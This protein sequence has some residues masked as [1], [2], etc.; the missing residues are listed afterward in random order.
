MF[1][2]HCN[3]DVVMMSNVLMNGTTHL[4]VLKIQLFIAGMV[5]EILLFVHHLMNCPNFVHKACA[6]VTCPIR[7]LSRIFMS[8]GGGGF[9]YVLLAGGS[10][11][12]IRTAFQYLTGSKLVA[13]HAEI[14]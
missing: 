7:F 4:K 6:K 14:I 13:G 10:C 12:I 3:D 8:G 2:L 5:P 11:V 1:G 9:D